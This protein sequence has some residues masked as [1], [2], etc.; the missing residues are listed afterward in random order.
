MKLSQDDQGS[1]QQGNDQFI[2]DH[3]LMQTHKFT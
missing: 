1:V 2:S 3:I